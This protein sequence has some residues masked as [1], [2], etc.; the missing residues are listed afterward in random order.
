MKNVSLI[1]T[2]G[3]SKSDPVKAQRKR[4]LSKFLNFFPKGFQD[5]KYHSWERDYKWNA[6]LKW[7]EALNEEKFRKLLDKKKYKEIASIAVNIESR[8]NLLFSFEKMALRDAVKEA[9]GARDFAHGIFDYIYGE[10]SI[11][12]RFEAFSEVLQILPRKQTRVHTWP[13]QTVFGFIADPASHIF[14]KP[15]VTQTA[16]VNYRY[17][18]EYSSKPNWD[19]YKSLLDFAKLIKKEHTELKPKDLIDLQSFIWVLGSSEY[20]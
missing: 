9:K 6:H 5:P 13:L 2:G 1:N 19:T 15:R 12:E 11:Q 7:D 8:T 4:C 3:R 10:G 17:D 18:F 20:D 14:L 16:A